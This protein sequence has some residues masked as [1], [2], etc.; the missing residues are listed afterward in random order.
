MGSPNIPTVHTSCIPTVQ[1]TLKTNLN[2]NGTPVLTPIS[3]ATAPPGGTD[4]TFS[5]EKKIARKV[6][7][8]TSLLYPSNI[9]SKQSKTTQKP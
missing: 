3:G 6:A 9:W 5:R 4:L 1:G 7:K 8:V 2:Q